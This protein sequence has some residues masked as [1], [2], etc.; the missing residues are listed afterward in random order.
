M[1]S[2]SVPPPPSGSASGRGADTRG[3][4][5]AA[6]FDLT[7]C[8]VLAGFAWRVAAHLEYVEWLVP[9]L[10]R[11][12]GSRSARHVENRR[13]HVLVDAVVRDLAPLALDELGLGRTAADLRALPEIADRRS[14]SAAYLSVEAAASEITSNAGVPLVTAL[15]A[16]AI[17]DRAAEAAHELGQGR[18]LRMAAIRAACAIEE[19]AYAG[20]RDPWTGALSAVELALA[21]REAVC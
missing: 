19:I 8:P 17:L 11:L 14:A 5:N 3:P 13:A 9:F 12:R 18:N 15:A 16:R 20:V 4:A 10:K 21:T 7:V 1:A 6:L 2:I